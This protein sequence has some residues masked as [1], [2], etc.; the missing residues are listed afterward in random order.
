[1]VY[2]VIPYPK[3][4]RFALDLFILG[5]I[6]ECNFNGMGLLAVRPLKKNLAF[7]L[8]PRLVQ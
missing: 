8:K 5:P 4:M 3:T 1:M 6:W 7:L 2:E